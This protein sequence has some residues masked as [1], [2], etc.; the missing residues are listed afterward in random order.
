MPRAGRDDGQ[1]R[2]R[3]DRS[4]ARQVHAGNT[5]PP[6]PSRPTRVLTAV[7]V[8]PTVLPPSLISHTARRQNLGFNIGLGALALGLG[9]GLA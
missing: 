4:H 7:W 6:S 5:R 3:A 2:Q 9:L 8:K 1:P